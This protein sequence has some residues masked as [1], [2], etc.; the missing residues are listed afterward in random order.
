[1]TKL[2]VITMC[3]LLAACGGGLGGSNLAVKVG[4]KDVSL[5]VKSSGTDKSVFTS[6]A[7]PGAPPITAT[8]MS[9]MLANYDMETTNIATMKKKMTAADQARVFFSLTGAEGTDLK[10]DFKPGTYK[11]DTQGKWMKVGMFSITTFADGKDAD[12][13]LDMM[14]S[15]SKA[16]GQITITSVTADEISG[17]IDV[18]EGDKSVKGDFTAKIAK[19]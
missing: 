1:M 2:I 7:G 11:V 4:G 10:A 5:A 15:M 19:K 3:A 9:V 17:S 16:T 12:A 6:T 8:T 13:S 14:S 18:S